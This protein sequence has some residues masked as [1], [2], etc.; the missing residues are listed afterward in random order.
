MSLCEYLFP[1]GFFQTQISLKYKD[2]MEYNQFESIFYINHFKLVL[3]YTDQRMIT[4]ICHKYI[5][6]VQGIKK[7]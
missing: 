5:Y 1:L 2:M 3:P 6:L 4:T 7:S